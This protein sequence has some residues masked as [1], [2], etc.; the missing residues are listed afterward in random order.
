MS[1]LYQNSDVD[2]NEDL[3]VGED[4]EVFEKDGSDQSTTK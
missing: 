4:F 1:F 3:F 2:E